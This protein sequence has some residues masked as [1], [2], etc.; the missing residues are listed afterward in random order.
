MENTIQEV[1]K[2]PISMTEYVLNMVV[3]YAAVG[4]EVLTEREKTSAINIITL[5]NLSLIHI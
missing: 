4:G 5:T 2:Q 3:N 1:K